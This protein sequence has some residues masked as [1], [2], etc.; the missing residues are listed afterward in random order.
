VRE[1]PPDVRRREL[2][3]PDP[4]DRRLRQSSPPSPL[5][6][7]WSLLM[8]RS[9][10]GMTPALTPA[11]IFLSVG[12]VM[13]PGML[14]WISPALLDR[15]SLA[16]TIA[17]AV[18][19]VLVGVAL[20]RELRHS[21]GLLLGASMESAVTT[22]MVGASAMFF[23]SRTGMAIDASLIGFALAL[24]LCASSSS[25]TS[26][27]PDSEPAAAIATRVADLDDVLPIALAVPGFALLAASTGG[28]LWVMVLA[29]AA[30][31]AAVGAI[32]WLLF[33][34]AESGPERV[35]FVLGA[36]SLAGGAAAYLHVSP[37]PVGLVA[38]VMWTLLPGRVDRVAENDLRRVQHPV[39]VLLLV[40]AGASATF[41]VAAVWLL[42]PYL[43]F[44]LAGKVSGAWIAAPYLDVRSSD[45]AAFLM[46]PGVLAVAFALNF[47]QML[48]AGS[49][50]A[51]L[52]TVAFGT[53]A[54]ELFALFVVPQWGARG[55][56]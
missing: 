52:A 43:L 22:V 53:A 32:G 25:A 8:T 56:R 34:R 35:L 44:R 5:A 17:L 27:D 21:A 38:G 10:L 14:G 3:G 12:F 4:I 18:L 39:V 1:V 28:D 55:H 16:V 20:G 36:L 7:I 29:P 11:V 54:F 41:S 23:I 6:P 33:E 15:L 9:A 50:Q 45:L 46:P 47:A 2:G 26:A 13:G 37:L 31:G 42:P 30:I 24:G 19:G 51:L 49:G 40:T 48:P